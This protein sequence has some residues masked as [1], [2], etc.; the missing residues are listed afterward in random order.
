M[1][2][3]GISIGIETNLLERGRDRTLGRG[4]RLETERAELSSNN[5]RECYKSKRYVRSHNSP[6]EMKSHEN[7]R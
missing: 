2:M 3:K 7:C 5:G 1:H 6:N 4:E